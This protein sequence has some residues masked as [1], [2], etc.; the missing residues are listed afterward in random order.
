M[1]AGWV[2]GLGRV[3]AEPREQ[4]E[5]WNTQFEKFYIEHYAR[6]VGILFRLTAS[7]GDAEELANEVFWKVYRRQAIPNPDGN[8]AG[9]LYR[10]ATNLGIDTLR[11]ES[12]RRQHESAAAHTAL[13]SRVADGPLT[14]VL[15]DERRRQVRGALA[16]LKPVQAQA[17][18]L[19]ASGFSYQEVAEALGVKRVSVGTLLLR[20][21]EAFRK[22]YRGTAGE[23]EKS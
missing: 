11:K 14:E 23:E 5:P 19:R 13:E 12:R 8:V 16:E 21:E 15:H 20:A 10:T 3:M 6:V 2:E 17:L 18:I 9:W 7:R 4:A 22:T 1:A